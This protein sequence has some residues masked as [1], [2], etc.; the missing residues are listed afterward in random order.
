MPRDLLEFRRH[1]DLVKMRQNEGSVTNHTF[2][3][4]DAKMS[5][6][7]TIFVVL[8]VCPVKWPDGQLHANQGARKCTVVNVRSRPKDAVEEALVLLHGVIPKSLGKLLEQLTLFGGQVSG[9]HYPRRH[10]HVAPAAALQ[11]GDA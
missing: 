4:T 11:S 7:R 9:R 2:Q 1:C 10:E 3:T 5:L 6:T 8:G